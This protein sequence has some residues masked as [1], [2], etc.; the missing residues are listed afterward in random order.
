M[1]RKEVRR[2]KEITN[3]KKFDQCTQTVEELS[4]VSSAMVS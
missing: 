3:I 2:L 1:L 4:V